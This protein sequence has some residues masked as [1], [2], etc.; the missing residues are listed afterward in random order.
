MKSLKMLL[1]FV[2]R[3]N[4][5]VRA[6]VLCEKLQ[7]CMIVNG[8]LCTSVTESEGSKQ[9]LS[10]YLCVCGLAW[11]VIRRMASSVPF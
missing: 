10:E 11:R 7:F 3:K 5:L 1:H 6:Q 9:E 2:A 8:L 4:V